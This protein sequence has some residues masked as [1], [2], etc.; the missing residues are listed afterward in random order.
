M[1]PE[2]PALIHTRD[3]AR[4][5]AGPL[6]GT[7]YHIHCARLM[8]DFAR[9]LGRS[10]DAERYERLAAEMATAFHRE[11]FRP[12]DGWYDN[13]TA[14]ACIL[15]L[16][17][18]LVP[19]GERARVAARLIDKLER[20]A[21]GHVMTGL[22]GCQWLMRTLTDVGRADLA[23]T[24][25]TRDTYPSWGHMVRNGATTIWEL[26]NGNTADPAMNS[27]NHGMLL[28]D[29]IIWMFEHLGGIANAPGETGFRRLRMRPE[30]TPECARVRAAYA[31]GHGRIESEWAAT[32]GEWI[33]EV[34]IPPGSSAEVWL[35]A[36]PA[37]AVRESGCP[38]ETA[39]G[40]GRV[41][42][43]RDRRV[44]EVGSGRY[45]FHVRR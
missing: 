21:G 35:P 27:H 5:T 41:R 38:L 25:A 24:L 30:V 45:R 40:I 29:L 3:P 18:G 13:G 19:E 22:I 36:A 32:E 4:K 16:R 39:V 26:W 1:P 7:A 9:R 11:L 33:W 12:A 44:V 20:E 6:I 31:A 37:A 42:Q 17:F 15:P 2:D 14:T 28:G 43:V 23:W 10:A 34:A 8:A